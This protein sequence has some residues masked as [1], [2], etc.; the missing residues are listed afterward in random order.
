MLWQFNRVLERCLSTTA[1]VI[2]IFGLINFNA[3]WLR[4]FYNFNVKDYLS[5]IECPTL[6]IGGEKDIQSNPGDASQIAREIPLAES[7]IIQNMNHLLRSF[8][9]VHKLLSSQWQYK[10]SVQEP[11]SEELLVT[12]D[13]W[14]ERQRLKP[15]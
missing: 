4:E 11:L 6:V 14:L 10:Q 3:K 7:H 5:N 9:G 12:I 1:S 15:L 2:K 13:R 8:S